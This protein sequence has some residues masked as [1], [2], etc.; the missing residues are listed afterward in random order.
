MFYTN[1]EQA[2][3]DNGLTV[4]QLLKNLGLST[5]FATRWKMGSQPKIDMIDKLAKALKCSPYNLIGQPTPTPAPTT[6]PITDYLI[7]EDKLSET[8]Q[9]LIDSFR[10]L[11]DFDR[12][13]Y[14]HKVMEMVKKSGAAD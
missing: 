13:E 2:C 6:P 4:T 9:L 5:S 8:E 1:L 11:D 3:M 10:N 7:T 12:I 14:L